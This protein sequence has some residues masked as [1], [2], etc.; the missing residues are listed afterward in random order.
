MTADPCEW[1]A[2]EDDIDSDVRDGL[3]HQADRPTPG[4]DLVPDLDSVG[5]LPADSG[6]ENRTPDRLTVLP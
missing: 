1:D 6:R 5:H 4:A 2:D 3:C